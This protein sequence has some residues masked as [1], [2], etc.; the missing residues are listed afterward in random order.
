MGDVLIF[1]PNV[2]AS[3]GFPQIRL[4]HPTLFTMFIP[5]AAGAVWASPLIFPGF[6]GKDFRWI[7]KT[8]LEIRKLIASN[9]NVRNLI[10]AC[11]WPSTPVQAK[12]L[13]LTST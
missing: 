5:L 8:L 4:I 2:V 3:Q 6:I 1:D 10:Q 13:Q 9:K 7:S 12:R 11:L